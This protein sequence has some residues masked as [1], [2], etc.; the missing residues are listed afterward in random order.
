MSVRYG[1]ITV[2]VRQLSAVSLERSGRKPALPPDVV[3][4]I[5]REHARGASLGEIAR[6]LNHDDI[7]TGQGG[8]QGW[9]PTMRAVLVRSEPP[10]SV[11]A[12]A[13]PA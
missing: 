1:L 8:R 6:R 12:A 3:A 5:R 11:R 7:P 10:R 9:P 2:S 13:P 4:R